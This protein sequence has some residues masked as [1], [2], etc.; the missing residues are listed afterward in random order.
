MPQGNF[1]VRFFTRG[2]RQTYEEMSSIETK[3][4]AMQTGF[5]RLGA[6]GSRMGPLV[7][8]GF[9]VMGVG[10]SGAMSLLRPFMN[11][12][13]LATKA[14]VGMGAAVAG[15]GVT[16]AT[17]FSFGLMRTREGFYLIETALG[18]VL[19]S[20]AAVRRLSEWAMEYAAKYPAMYED[21]MEAMKGMAMMS[22]LKPMFLRDSREELEKI[23]NIVQGLA[24][25]DPQQG[26]RGALYAIRE[27]LAGQWRTLMY[28]FEIRPEEVARAA[29]LT[30]EQLRE[31][32]E[33]AIKALDAF[34]KLNV[35]AE[36]LR[37][38][39]ESLGIQWGNL[40]DKYKQWINI[41]AQ[42]GPYQKLVDLLM[43]MNEWLDKLLKS[44]GT[45]DFGKTIA[46]LYMGAIEGVRSLMTKGVDLDEKSLFANLKQIFNN[47]KDAFK[48]LWR[49]VGGLTKDGFKLILSY[50]AD[51]MIW[52]ARSVLIPVG[53]SLAKGLLEGL[54]EELRKH[55]ITAWVLSMVVGGAI[56]KGPGA[57]AG[58]AMSS[59]WLAYEQ[60]KEW[61]KKPEEG[62][63]VVRKR[64]APE[65]TPE[66]REREDLKTR[67]SKELDRLWRELEKRLPQVKEIPK[68]GKE[69]PP[70]P[71]KKEPSE[72][73][74]RK[75]EE[76]KEMKK[77]LTNRIKQL[78]LEEL[79]YR[80][81]ALNQE[82]Q[83]LLEKYADEKEMI[84]LIRQYERAQLDELNE[85]Y[86]EA[87]EEREKAQREAN[88]KSLES[89]KNWVAGILDG[90]DTVVKGTR[91]VFQQWRDLAV[92]T[93]Q[94]MQEAFSDLFFDAMQ[95]N[96][97]SL[98]DYVNA[99]L[100][101][102]QR[103][104][105]DLMA[106]G[107]T[108][109]ITGY[110]GA[111][112]GSPGTAKPAAP[113]GVEAIWTH[114]GGIIGETSFPKRTMPAAAFMG[115]KRAHE[116]LRWDE[117]PVIVQRGEEIISKQDRTR[118][119]PGRDGSDVTVNIH[120]Y[121]GQPV[122][123]KKRSGLFGGRKSIEVTIG[124]LVAKDVTSGGPVYS[125]M[126][127]TFGLNPAV[128]SR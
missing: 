2:Y 88:Q 18:G 102:V 61:L 6:E 60:I 24:A 103:S 49:E 64:I 30:M 123:V 112:F 120:N 32:P 113:A 50:M 100:A 7:S 69:E 111:W 82:V 106:E 74:L 42:Y 121:T 68:P 118:E 43:E 99:F 109:G 83:A 37:K 29:G 13:M 28:R 63:P 90:L 119:M 70:P 84:D 39:A 5:M 81:W 125:A 85:A 80:R 16:L 78:T 12:V 55:P 22:A 44:K 117:Y 110:V 66:E 26:V 124:Q 73:E 86:L 14:L 20:E 92:D 95:G 59:V 17:K 126:K 8:R 122:D 79:D 104:F 10:I 34:V 31:S 58:G 57:L 48:G 67:I 53:A 128:G 56:A 23:M 96:L 77:Q 35:G 25:L 91:S 3:S 46:R 114:S 71:E 54:K 116:G 72:A 1:G 87:M 51:A 47:V 101:S 19:K 52:F 38:T 40:S 33:L 27:A 75:M 98:S 76:I 65:L 93:A 127:R 45:E 97:K 36:T 9:G 89:S 21:V 105:A 115:A 62:G 15:I 4:K 107:L 11:L 94:G 41:I 108:K